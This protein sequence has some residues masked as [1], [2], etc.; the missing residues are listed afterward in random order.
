MLIL[1]CIHWLNDSILRFG[2]GS[3]SDL[4]QSIKHSPIRD[5]EAWSTPHTTV[6]LGKLKNRFLSSQLMA[7]SDAICNIL[8]TLWLFAQKKELQQ[9]ERI[10]N[11][12]ANVVYDMNCNNSKL[13][14]LVVQTF[15]SSSSVSCCSMFVF[16]FM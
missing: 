12:A 2:S 5:M 16:V 13:S 9:H 3:K 15:I 4:A 11:K 8:S 6:E 10:H 1:D 7:S 14:L